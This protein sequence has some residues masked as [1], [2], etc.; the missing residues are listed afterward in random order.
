MCD[1][2]IVLNNG[3]VIGISVYKETMNAVPNHKQKDMPIIPGLAQTSSV[4][5]MPLIAPVKKVSK[6]GLKR[7]RPSKTKSSEQLIIPKLTTQQLQQ[8]Q[9]TQQLHQLQQLQQSTINNPNQLQQLQQST[10]N[11]PTQ[12]QN[13]E[14]PWGVSSTND[15]NQTEENCNAMVSS[16]TFGDFS[17]EDSNSH[18]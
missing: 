16:A 12:Q 13:Y 18:P 2:R 8:Q 10:I 3:D 11:N 7:G 9:I 14:F 1:Q 15:Q 4:S 5:T 17:D 6:S